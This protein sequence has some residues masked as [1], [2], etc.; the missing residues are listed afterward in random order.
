MK[1]FLIILSK[2]M[3]DT[4]SEV[5]T[6]LLSPTTS[7]S[8]TIVLI[9]EGVNLTQ[10]P[11]ERTY[12]LEDDVTN[13]NGQSCTFPKISYHDMVTMIFEADMVMTF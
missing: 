1:T 6:S 11:T 13:N 10:L 4:Y 7:L 5:L 12:A 8:F 2:N 9:Q 3:C